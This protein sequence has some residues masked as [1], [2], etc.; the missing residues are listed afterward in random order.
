MDVGGVSLNEN[1]GAKEPKE[2]KE[3]KERARGEADLRG[4]ALCLLVF[5]FLLYRI[6]Q[7]PVKQYRAVEHCKLQLP[8]F[9]RK[10]ISYSSTG[11]LRKPRRKVPT[12][13]PMT[14]ATMY[15]GQLPTTGNT[16]M[17]P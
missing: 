7:L 14:S 15:M 2:P 6:V 8:V 4:P 5:T 16:K 11:F 1:A 17:P 13:V 10:A 3:P 9:Q 12:M